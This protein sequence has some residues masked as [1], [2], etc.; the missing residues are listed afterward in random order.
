MLAYLKSLISSILTLYL[1]KLIQE[2]P[3]VSFIL[4]NEDMIDQ[5]RLFEEKI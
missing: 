3:A 2:N 1:D 4:Q 5:V